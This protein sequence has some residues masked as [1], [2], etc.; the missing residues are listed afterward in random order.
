ML[1]ID[2]GNSRIKWAVFAGDKI[3]RSGVFEYDVVHL[4]SAINN[5]NLP[6]EM[7]TEAQAIAVSCVANADIKNRVK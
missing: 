5:T 6:A 7:Q 2:I 4:E 3:Q 1:A